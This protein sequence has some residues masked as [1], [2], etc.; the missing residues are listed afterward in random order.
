MRSIPSACGMVR[1]TPS[2]IT[3][4]AASGLAELVAHDAQDDVVAHQVTSLHDRLGLEAERRAALDGVAQEVAGG[5]LGKPERFGQ[6][7]ALG[8]LAGPGG[9]MRRMSTA[10]PS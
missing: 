5:E 8:A 2:K 7:R 4:L 1:T 10:A 9:P 3:P 6:Q